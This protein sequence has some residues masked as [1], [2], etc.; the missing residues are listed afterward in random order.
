MREKIV[1][2][3]IFSILLVLIKW[4][5]FLYEEEAKVDFSNAKTGIMS[6][7]L[8]DIKFEPH[9]QI[10]QTIEEAQEE[11][12][13]LLLTHPLLFLPNSALL[14]Y[15]K[16]KNIPLD[17][18]KTVTYAEEN[19]TKI[20]A[21][22]V[23]ILKSVSTDMALTITA[24]SEIEGKNSYN[25]QLSQKRADSVYQYLQVQHPVKFMNAIGYGE[26]FPLSIEENRTILN[27]RIEIELKRI[28]L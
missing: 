5:F 19:N 3:L 9:P 6:E 16:S 2:L 18:N 22:V 17:N 13:Q 14:N 7:L 27:R 1:F 26:E 15:N 25:R 11:L 10:T 4:C 20:L 12:T 8:M 23:S 24:H 21:E 28:K